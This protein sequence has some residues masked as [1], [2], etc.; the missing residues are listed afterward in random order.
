M[1]GS[2]S[3][4]LSGCLGVQQDTTGQ[5]LLV[6]QGGDSPFEKASS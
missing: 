3:L 6:V 4:R 2:A 5:V 1:N